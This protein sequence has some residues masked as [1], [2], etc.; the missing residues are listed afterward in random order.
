MPSLGIFEKKSSFLLA[1]ALAFLLISAVHF[2][3]VRA[4][5]PAIPGSE[6]YSEMEL[7]RA[8]AGNS[9][10]VSWPNISPLVGLLSFLSGFIGLEL[11]A[12]AV[13]LILGLISLVLFYLVMGTLGVTYDKRVIAGL[14]LVLS[15]AYIFFYSGPYEAGLILPIILLSAYLFSLKHAAAKITAILLLL[16]TAMVSILNL[17]LVLVMAVWWVASRV[18]KSWFTLPAGLAYVALLFI[19][20]SRLVVAYP[21]KN[22]ISTLLFDL[23]HGSGLGTFAVIL[24]AVGMLAL[25]R[26]R[27]EFSLFYLVLPFFLLTL[28]FSDMGN[29]YLA[30][31]IAFF[32]AHG[33]G[34]F[35][36]M[37]W[38]ISALKGL[39]ILIL[40][41]GLLFSSLSAVKVNLQAMPDSGL[42]TALSWV[43]E[44]S[45][46]GGQVLSSEENGFWIR[47][48]GE[49][50]AVLDS[51][52]SPFLEPGL[53]N[54][55]SAIFYSRNL[56]KTRELLKRYEVST[57]MIDQQMRQGAIWT[58]DDEGLL[59]LFRNNETFKRDF[60]TPEIE[61]WSVRLSEGNG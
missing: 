7:A 55:T 53:L 45:K 38:E 39:T 32:A 33:L 21:M 47:Y 49:R 58:R 5:S 46:A 44:N 57:I 43:K 34:L 54:G 60:A 22:P 42:V 13:S 31:I 41:C 61:I 30:F 35:I 1:I 17:M 25:W 14:V 51:H 2:M 10:W 8:A 40:V 3:R 36:D 19:Y 18:K 27:D 26:K 23:G 59:F 24:C 11:S 50:P 52:I 16:F 20:I 48:F 15:P 28:F 9:S 12:R 6:P 4:G 56:E 29:L 37:K